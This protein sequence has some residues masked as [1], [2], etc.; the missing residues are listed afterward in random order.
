MNKYISWRT[1]KELDGGIQHVASCRFSGR[2]IP[3]DECSCNCY[4]NTIFE[5]GREDMRNEVIEDINELNEQSKRNSWER[6]ARE[7]GI[8]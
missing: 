6:S 1:R 2:S 3:I 8:K 5:A 4:E 7:G